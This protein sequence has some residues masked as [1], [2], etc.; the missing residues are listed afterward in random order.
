MGW[1]AVGLRYRGMTEYDV[2]YSKSVQKL[3]SPSHDDLYR[4]DKAM[5]G[6]FT[7]GLSV[8]ECL[9]F[10]IYCI[11]AMTSKGAITISESKDL[12]V[13][14]N[15][16]VGEFQKVFIGESILTKMEA[17]LAEKEYEKLNGFRNVLSHRGYLP[18]K[19]F[20]GGD[21]DGKI[22][23]P[24]NPKDIP[25]QWQYDYL[26]DENTTSVFR[27]WIVSKLAELITEL[28]TF[29]GRYFRTT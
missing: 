4:Q 19:Y 9:F 1:N 22:T 21:N 2:E 15:D 5:V 13:Y 18:R 20:K 8:L 3:A 11:G 6:F 14:P 24:S 17:V 25:T 29:C 26:V 23:M 16:I 7:S 27:K 10:S 12:R 28:E